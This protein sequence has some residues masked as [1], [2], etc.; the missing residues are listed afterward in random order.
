M[1][2]SEGP[3]H[4][5]STLLHVREKCCAFFPLQHLSI[6]SHFELQYWDIF[7]AQHKISFIKPGRFAACLFNIQRQKIN[8]NLM[9]SI[10]QP[11]QP[12]KCTC[13]HSV[14]DVYECQA[15]ETNSD[16]KNLHLFSPHA[17]VAG[18]CW[19]RL[20]IVSSFITETSGHSLASRELKL[21]WPLKFG[22]KKQGNFYF[23]GEPETTRTYVSLMCFSM[24]S[25]RVYNYFS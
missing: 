23:G 14:F 11:L 2:A 4:Y 20:K 1:C 17:S 18:H 10:F 19:K 9:T 21:V 7:Q 24:H 13:A 25:C 5:T 22:A 3:L 12:T 6:C 15:S 8:N 16:S